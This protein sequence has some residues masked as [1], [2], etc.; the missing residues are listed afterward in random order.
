[1][2]TPMALSV[3]SS[4]REQTLYDFKCRGCQGRTFAQRE[5]SK[6]SASV[7]LKRFSTPSLTLKFL[8]AG[9]LYP[10]LVTFVTSPLTTEFARF[11]P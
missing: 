7:H 11:S 10:R 3:T 1:M 6:S 8:C 2:K 5:T 4:Q 9:K